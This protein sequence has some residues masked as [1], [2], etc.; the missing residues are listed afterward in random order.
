MSSVPHGLQLDADHSFPGPSQLTTKCTIFHPFSCI[1]N[2]AVWLSHL[3]VYRAFAMHCCKS[4]LVLAVSYHTVLIP[5]LNLLFSDVT[6]TFS[7]V[8]D[9]HGYC[10]ILKNKNCTPVCLRQHGDGEILVALCK[11]WE[12][13]DKD[14]GGS[15]RTIR[16]GKSSNCLFALFVFRG[17]SRTNTLQL[18]LNQTWCYWNH[19]LWQPHAYEHSNENKWATGQQAQAHCCIKCDQRNRTTTQ[20]SLLLWCSEGSDGPRLSPEPCASEKG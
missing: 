2:P 17:A 7:R 12:A 8:I 11:P 3:G 18:S 10:D 6:F 15:G 14:V 4:V 5:L 9:G 13:R 16:P 1:P 19:R 20:K